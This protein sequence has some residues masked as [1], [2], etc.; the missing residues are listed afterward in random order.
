MSTQIGT[1]INDKRQTQCS[2]NNHESDNFSNVFENQGTNIFSTESCRFYFLHPLSENALKNI[3]WYF[4]KCFT[5][6]FVMLK[7]IHKNIK[8]CS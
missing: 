8:I 1:K 6:R 7:Y 4:D 3:P 2:Y 5:I